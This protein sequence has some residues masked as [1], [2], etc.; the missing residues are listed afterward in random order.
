MANILDPN[1]SISSGYDLWNVEL[2][3]GESHQGIISSETDV[4]IT[5]KNNG[6]LEKTINR[7]NI[8]VIK[9][10]E[11]SASDAGF[12]VLKDD[13]FSANRSG[14]SL[15]PP[16]MGTPSRSPVPSKTCSRSGAQKYRC[17]PNLKSPLGRNYPASKQHPCSPSEFSALAPAQTCGPFSMR[18]K[19]VSSKRV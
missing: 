19:Q 12:V 11:I 2:K 16:I 13:L 8:K 10:M 9:S 4:A 5:L 14:D 7:Q 1:I 6:K 15:W 17:L 3:N 18:S